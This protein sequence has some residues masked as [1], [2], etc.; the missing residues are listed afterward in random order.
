MK[1]SK[2][3]MES[4]LRLPANAR[5]KHFVKVVVDWEEAWGLYNDGWALA[6]TDDGV[7]VFPLWPAREYAELCAAGEWL[8]F[9]AKPISLRYLV[10]ELL[11]ALKEDGILPGVFCLP[12]DKGVTPAASDLLSDLNEEIKKYG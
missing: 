5:Y 6:S 11:P 8:K 1:I 9:V 4:M 2:I 3:Q 12:S 10:G 7:Q